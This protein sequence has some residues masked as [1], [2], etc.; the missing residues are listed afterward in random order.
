[1]TIDFSGFTDT[2]DQADLREALRDFLSTHGTSA[3]VR[4]AIAS[5]AGYDQAAWKR[6]TGELGLTA[7]AVPEDLG[8]AGATLAEVAVAVQEIGRVLLPVPYLPT[9]LT[10]ALLAE[11]GGPATEQFLPGL[12]DGTLI[13]ALAFGPGVVTF[14]DGQLSGTVRNVL[15]G[16]LADVFLVRVGGALVAV[17]AAD[18]EVAPVGTLDQTRGQA[19]LSFRDAPALRVSPEGDGGEFA[20][21]AADL[22]RAFL[23]A[24]S[25]AA[26]V[27]CLDRCVEYLKTRVQFGRL[28]GEFQALKHRAADLAVAAESAWM[29]AHAAIQAAVS[30]PAEFAVAAPLAKRYCADA[31]FSVAAETIQLHGGIGFTWEHDA[32]LYFKRAK[33]TQLL[34]GTPAEL[35][36][37]VARRA[38]LLGLCSPRDWLGSRF[39]SLEQ[40]KSRT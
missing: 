28:I 17:R 31:F 22:M 9:A 18:A 4:Q 27:R 26:A 20:D 3:R 8:G 40:Q 35:R 32:H 36:H 15:D 38:A 25:A 24:E 14:G 37:E 23:A 2:A 6:L 11:A 34:H 30:D 39:L 16:Q 1:M 21:R 19:T 33:S 13:G 29:T 12:M 7:L 5:P 10:A